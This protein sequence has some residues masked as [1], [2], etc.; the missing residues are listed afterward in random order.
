[1]KDI[2]TQQNFYENK[3]NNIEFMDEEVF[4]EVYIYSIYIYIY[5]R[6]SWIC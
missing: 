2:Q 5:Y 4:D 3:Y 1:M 6:C